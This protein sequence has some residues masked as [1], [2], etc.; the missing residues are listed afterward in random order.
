MQLQFK[1]CTPQIAKEVRILRIGTFFGCLVVIINLICLA[2]K[3]DFISVVLGNIILLE[4]PMCDSK[5]VAR[6]AVSA[7]V[8]P[9]RLS[10]F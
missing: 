7:T 3:H 8:H 6:D 9:D 2:M 5:D 4:G 1:K 10:F